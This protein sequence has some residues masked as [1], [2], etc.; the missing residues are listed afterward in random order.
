MPR[1][2]AHYTWTP[3]QRGPKE[4]YRHYVAVLERTMRRLKQMGEAGDQAMK[5][6]CQHRHDICAALRDA[7]MIEQAER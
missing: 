7:A 3:P 6:K 4:P 5:K 2:G 1:E